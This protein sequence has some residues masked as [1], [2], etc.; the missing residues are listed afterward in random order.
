MSDRPTGRDPLAV[1]AVLLAVT[2]FAGSFDHVRTVVADHGQTGWLSWAIAAMP[3]VSVVLAVLKVRRARST[4]EPVAWAWVVGG[5]AAAFTL[6]ANIA[7]AEPSPWGPTCSWS[8][9][10]SPRTSTGP[11]SGSPVPPCR[12]ASVPAGTPARPAGRKPC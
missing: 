9:R 4:G 8:G 2:A 7:T 11:G 10:R 3:E 1:A 5:S 12:P 6:A